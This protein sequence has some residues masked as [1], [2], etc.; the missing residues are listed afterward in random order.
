MIARRRRRKPAAHLRIRIQIPQIEP[1]G[2]IDRAKRRRMSRVPF[3]VVH[4][5]VRLVERVQRRD[6]VRLCR[7]L[8]EATCAPQLDRPVDR[9]REEQV[10]K[11]NGPDE[12]VEVQPHDWPRVAAVNVVLV[13]P[14]LG[15][16]AVVPVC[17]ID[18]ALLRANPEGC[19]FVVGEVEGGSG[20]FTRLIMT[21][22][23]QLKC[24][25]PTDRCYKLLGG[26]YEDKHQPGVARAYPPANCKLCH[27]CCWLSDCVHFACP[28]FAW[29]KLG[30][31]V[32][33][34][35]VAS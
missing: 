8:R 24:F 6:R 1:P 22:V 29:H 34:Q 9:A 10:R 12:R 18:V 23:H 2:P 17:L 33:P 21:G 19:R 5:V 32:Q 27:L 13:E 4:I 16:C 7:R 3:D 28:P 30:A 35:I 26:I 31:Y 25:L 11:V 20:N 14:R 15:T